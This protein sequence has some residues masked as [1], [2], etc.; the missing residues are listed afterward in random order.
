MQEF[1]EQMEDS[2]VPG[3]PSLLNPSYQPPDGERMTVLKAALAHE[4]GLEEW[5]MDHVQAQGNCVRRAWQRCDRE[6]Q[7]GCQE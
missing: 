4:S 6:D 2:N 7:M 1:A 3:D 5:E